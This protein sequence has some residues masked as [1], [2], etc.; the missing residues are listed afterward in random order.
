MLKWWN[1]KV[2]M[3][4]MEMERRW[5]IQ[6]H[7]QLISQKWACQTELWYWTASAWEKE[8]PWKTEYQERRL[9]IIILTTTRVSPRPNSPTRGFFPKPNTAASGVSPRPNRRPP[10]STHSDNLDS[11]L[12]E[13]NPIQM[14]PCTNP[15]FSS[16][17]LP[18]PPCWN[19]PSPQNHTTPQLS[20]ESFNQWDWLI[21]ARSRLH[22]WHE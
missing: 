12:L 6:V 4:P 22:Y 9:Y 3:L 11:T 1:V 2:V 21:C 10:I 14:T 15:T 7:A 8:W 20:S 5:G 16:L 13:T 19:S 18:N 17:Y